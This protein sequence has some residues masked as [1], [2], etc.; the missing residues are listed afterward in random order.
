MIELLVTIAVLVVVMSLLAYPI[1][2]AYGY[3][4][5]ARARSDAQNAGDIALRQ[6]TKDLN[7][8]M[9]I[10]DIPPDGSM[11]T[12]VPGAS[13]LSGQALTSGGNTT[14]VRYMQVLDMPWVANGQGAWSLLTPNY[15]PYSTATAPNTYGY[16]VNG[17]YAPFWDQSRTAFSTNP[18]IVARYELDAGSNTTP[19]TTWSAVQGYAQDGLFPLDYTANGTPL[20]PVQNAG[21]FPLAPSMLQQNFRSQCV[22]ISPL[23]TAWD[24]PRFQVTPYAASNESLAIPAYAAG[25]KNTSLAQSR[26]PLW[27]GH[28]TDLDTLS[29]TQR[30]NYY[31]FPAATLNT[32]VSA[33]YPI[34]AG[35]NPFG[36]SIKIFDNSPVLANGQPNPAFG[37]LV[38]GSGG[39]QGF[40]IFNRHFMDWPPTIADSGYDQWQSTTAIGPWDNAVWN[41]ATIQ[42]QRLEG[43]VVFAEPTSAS[44]LTVDN[45][46]LPPSGTDTNVLA[47]AT[48]PLPS[49]W[50]VLYSP[51]F[52]TGNT[53]PG[54][55]ANYFT[56]LASVPEKF[57]MNGKIYKRVLTVNQLTPSA[58]TGSVTTGTFYL[59]NAGLYNSS[60]RVIWFGDAIPASATPYPLAAPLSYRICDLQPTDVVVA[61]YS[62]N[63]VLDIA[64]TI[65]RQDVVGHTPAQQRQDYT[66]RAHIVA[67]NAIKHARSSQ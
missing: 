48:L 33:M 58:T 55:P 13:D 5:K 22:A 40:P 12:F 60:S 20:F 43:K 38:Y 28:N 26:Y 34:G 27:V 23:G 36:Y 37:Q 30:T 18:Y 56:Y 32:Q 1:Y 47:S 51:T 35:T 44:S 10:F 61:N 24:V 45:S 16:K 67:M 59:P 46:Y 31:G 8:A 54:Y 65:S 66:A 64:M 7:N 9:L 39:Q 2:A 14:I 57:T 50:N 21:G 52:I 53:V 4:Q 25:A 3:I 15:P 29:D 41:Q 49:N 62:T 6:L 19:P 42:R 63:G 11:V 17:H